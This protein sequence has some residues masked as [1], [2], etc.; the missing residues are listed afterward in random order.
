MKKALGRLIVQ[1]DIVVCPHCQEPLIELEQPFELRGVSIRD[2]LV[3]T[4][5]GSVKLSTA[6]RFLLMLML[7]CFPNTVQHSNLTYLYYALSSVRGED[8]GSGETIRVQIYRIR[9]A[10]APIGI[11][12]LTIWNTGYRLDLSALETP[13]CP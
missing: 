12:L 8:S 3:T 6:Q 11:T 13:E 2:N 4:R 10:L 9:R 7:Q 5:L 1:H